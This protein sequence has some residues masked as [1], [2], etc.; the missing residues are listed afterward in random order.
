MKISTVKSIKE[1]SDLDISNLQNK[2]IIQNNLVYL[3]GLPS[4]LANKDLLMK[5][6]YMGQYG[7]IKK[8]NIISSKG[9]KDFKSLGQTYAA[10]ITYSNSQ[11]SSLAILSLNGMIIDNH[12]IKAL[13]GTTKYCSYFLQSTSC[14]TRDCQ[15]LHQFQENE[16]SIDKESK[17]ENQHFS[18]ALKLSKVESLELNDDL[19]SSKKKTSIF[20]EINELRDNPTISDYISKNKANSNKMKL[21]ICSNSSNSTSNSS[22]TKKEQANSKLG[23]LLSKGKAKKRLQSKS[24]L[25]GNCL[26]SF[27]EIELNTLNRNSSLNSICSESKANNMESGDTSN[28]KFSKNK[29][30]SR[31]KFELSTS[32]GSNLKEEESVLIP[33]ELRLIILSRLKNNKKSVCCINPPKADFDYNSNLNDWI[34]Q[35][36]TVNK[37]SSNLH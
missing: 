9:N 11:E 31:F 5:F 15:Y 23:N 34:A 33:E 19:L 25:Q 28:S 3:L 35:F 18:L 27:S 1:Y 30:Q 13:Y 2:R 37:D 16:L 24:K 26:T 7:K 14:L 12:T 8:I 32:E 4:K 10:Y 21:S 22:S 6:E 36:V 20:P 17:E 29:E